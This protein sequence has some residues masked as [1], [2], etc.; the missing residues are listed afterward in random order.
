MRVYLDNCC[1]NRPFDDQNQLRIALESA[2]KLAIQAQ[3]RSGEIEYVW[4][5]R[6]PMDYTA[7]REKHMYLD[8]DVH[9]L[10]ERARATARRF[11]AMNGDYTRLR[12]GVFDCADVASELDGKVSAWKSSNRESVLA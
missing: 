1:Y 2:A 9:S 7:W 8:E 12:D 10:A 3:M 11:D 4:S 6:E 5:D